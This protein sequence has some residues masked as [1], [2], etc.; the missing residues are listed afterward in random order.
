MN[1]QQRVANITHVLAIFMTHFI[2]FKI[3]NYRLS[4]DWPN[5]NPNLCFCYQ[6]LSFSFI[7]YRSLSI[8][9]DRSVSLSITLYRF[10]SLFIVVYRC[11]F[12]ERTNH[13]YVDKGKRTLKSIVRSHIIQMLISNNLWTNVVCHSK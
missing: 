8:A 10:L 2:S 5:L 13:I 12:H 4:I 3:G 6:S 9:L 11:V 1:R 7:R